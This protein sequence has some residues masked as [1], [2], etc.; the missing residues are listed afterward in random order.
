MTPQG[1]PTPE[2]VHAA[3]LQGEEAVLALLGMFTALIL[4]LQPNPPGTGQRPRG[5]PGEKQPQQQQAPEQRRLA[6]APHPQSPHP[7][8]EKA[9]RSARP[10]GPYVAS[11]GA[12]RPSPPVPRRAL[13]GLWGLVAGGAPQYLRAPAGVCAAAGA[14]GGHGAS[15]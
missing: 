1:L 12:T 8:R 6:E 7:Q 15:C 3:Y 11:R 9:W 5:P 13:G 4:N 2:D 14:H 10:R